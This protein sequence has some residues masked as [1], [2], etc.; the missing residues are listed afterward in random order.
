ML[1]LL[2]RL[3][4][5]A[6]ARM[7]PVRFHA[8]PNWAG[9][10]ARCTT[11]IVAVLMFLHANPVMAQEASPGAWPKFPLNGHNITRGPGGYLCWWKL[12]ILWLFFLLWVK[13]VDWTAKDC[14]ENEFDHSV[15][16]PVVFVPFLLAM[17]SGALT[18][19]MF[20]IG[21]IVAA[22]AA[23]VPSL[24]YVRHRN[25]QLDPHL[26]VLTPDH[27]R[28]LIGGAGAEKKADYEKG[29]PVTFLPLTSKDD[30][31]NQ[32]S[33]ISAR[34]S[35]GFLPAKAMIANA[36]DHRANKIMMDFT[37]NEVVSK[38]QVDGVWHDSDGHDREEGDM[39]LEVIKR[40][41]GGNPEE[42]RKRQQGRFRTE[43]DGGKLDT[44][45]L[46]QG[47]KTGERAVMTFAGKTSA[48]FK[49][50]EDLGMRDK[51]IEQFKA[52][53]LEPKGFIVLASMK[54]DGLTTTLA[55]ALAN[56]DRLMR[57]VLIIE[58]EATATPEVENVEPIFFNAAAGESPITKLDAALR[59]QPDFVVV[60][61]LHNK[62]SG[63]RLCAAAS[64]D[65]LVMT[66]MNAK[67]GVEALLRILML[68]IPAKE[69][70]PTVVG[71]LNQ[72]LIRKLCETC[73]EAYEPP[74]ALL[75]K[76]GIPAGRVE[77]LYRHPE[78]P[79]EV[80]EDCHGI[81][82]KGRMAIFELLKVDDTMKEVLI[83]QPKLDILRKA[84]RKAG[85]RSLQEEGI[86]AVVKGLTSLPELM[87]VLKQ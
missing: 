83:K 20:A 54:S 87:R 75:K 32:A 37:A 45:L 10:D 3:N 46:T 22:L 2:N 33:L 28:Y 47:T 6:A 64:S 55:T 56:T 65:Q 41:A 59:K 7:N 19:P 62:E 26:R 21:G 85:N 35:D 58:D 27:I 9:I 76:L 51:M 39:I 44:T 80:C 52:L 82:Y 18:I 15:W 43:Y 38:F 23:I 61:V 36:I 60:P 78:N 42:R 34:Q 68:K 29:S 5:L 48:Q 1:R 11:S 40:L 77:E 4:C 16:L 25:A 66:T 81:G 71:V 72:R 69:F 79:E 74:P 31:K 49:K 70:A 8:L 84:S 13:A 73:K 24:I 12:L 63:S 86:L 30:Q 53:M 14:K 17:F 67:E 50:L 57:D